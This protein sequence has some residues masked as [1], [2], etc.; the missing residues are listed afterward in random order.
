M[1]DKIPLPVPKRISS[2][3]PANRLQALRG[4]Q[5]RSASNSSRLSQVSQ[6]SL[7]SATSDFLDAKIAALEDEK[8]YISC[9]KEGLD[10]L[11]SSGLL[12]S[13]AFQ[14]EIGPVLRGF[15]TQNPRSMCFWV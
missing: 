12:S 6:D 4:H 13:N 11:S 9:L 3:M 15:Y 10:E 1:P 14:T 2:L 5:E 8:E 7:E